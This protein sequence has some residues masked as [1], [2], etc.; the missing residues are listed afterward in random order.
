MSLV[1]LETVK[2]S[3]INLS[4]TSYYKKKQ[5]NFVRKKL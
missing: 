3:T 5:Q 1:N 4:L 2:Q